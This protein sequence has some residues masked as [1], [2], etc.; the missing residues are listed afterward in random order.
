[1]FEALEIVELEI[2]LSG[3][4]RLLLQRMHECGG[5]VGIQLAVKR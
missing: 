5:R 3:R 4:G 2:G 1:M